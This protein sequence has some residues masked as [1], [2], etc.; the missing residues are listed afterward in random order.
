VLLLDVNRFTEGDRILV[1]LAEVLRSCVPAGGLSC[2]LG[3]DRFAVVLPDLAFAEQAHDVAGAIA[4]ALA[5]VIVD[6]RLTPLSA[7]IGLAVAAP[8]ELT[9]DEL[10][11]R[12]EL[13]MH[14]AKRRAPETRWA[15]WQDDVSRRDAA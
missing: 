4:S 11:D 9:H 10:V 6:G 14:R 2:R 1:E 3:G 5:P 15:V 13:A 8:G 12:A 7:G